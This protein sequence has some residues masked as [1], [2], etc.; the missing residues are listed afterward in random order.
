MNDGQHILFLSG[1]SSGKFAVK[2]QWSGYLFHC[3]RHLQTETL[4]TSGIT[5]LQHLEVLRL[6]KS[7][8]MSWLILNA[9]PVEHIFGSIIQ[10]LSQ[11]VRHSLRQDNFFR[12]SA[13][14]VLNKW[15]IEDCGWILRELGNKII[16]DCATLEPIELKINR[17]VLCL[18]EKYKISEWNLVN[19]S[20]HIQNFNSVPVLFHWI[21]E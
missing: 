8:W 17:R 4:P 20:E 11:D 7:C 16:T 2:C 21:K 14:T 9:L 19:T 12:I 18:V 13:N 15:I 1:V 10:V 5:R 3:Y 6:M